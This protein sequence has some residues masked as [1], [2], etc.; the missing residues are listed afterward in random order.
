MGVGW[1]KRPQIQ[2]KQEKRELINLGTESV[3]AEIKCCPVI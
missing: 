1:G 3:T 2:T